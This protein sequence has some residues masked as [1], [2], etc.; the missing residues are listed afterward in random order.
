MSNNLVRATNF[1]SVRVL[2]STD[3]EIT[4]RDYYL[5]CTPLGLITI[6]IPKRVKVVFEVSYSSNK[7]CSKYPKLLSVSAFTSLPLRKSPPKGFRG[8]HVVIATIAKTKQRS[9]SFPA[10]FSSQADKKI[11]QLF[12]LPVDPVT[13]ALIL[14][15]ICLV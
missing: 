13:I 3:L 7:T 11:E 15:R 9:N 12:I 1:K 6:A 14:I 8:L 5:N 10:I 2:R 4:P